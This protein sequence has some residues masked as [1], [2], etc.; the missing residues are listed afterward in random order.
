LRD[1][2]R[3]L[4]RNTIRH[5][6][7]NLEGLDD[8]IKSLQNN[9]DMTKKMDLEYN[10]N[11]VLSDMPR[12]SSTTNKIESCVMTRLELIEKLEKE[13]LYFLEIQ[14]KINKVILMNLTEKEKVVYRLRFREKENGDKSFD[15]I[16]SVLCT[17]KSTVMFHENNIISKIERVWH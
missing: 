6:L 3:T 4:L 14:R 11:S 2:R 5:Y 15:E 10:I 7:H 8:T 16:T 9:I 13:L 17:S 12:S 1:K